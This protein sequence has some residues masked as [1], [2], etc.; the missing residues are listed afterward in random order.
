MLRVPNTRNDSVVK[1]LDY[2]KVY[3][4]PTGNQ[5]N[6]TFIA[7]ITGQ[8]TFQLINAIG[9]TVLSATIQQGINANFDVRNLTNGIYFWRLTDSNRIISSGKES[10]VK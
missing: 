2:V 6:L 3:P 10:I 4:N 7:N 9:Q 8:A 1:P 5:L